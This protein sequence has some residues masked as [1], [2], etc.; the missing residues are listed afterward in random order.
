MQ[1]SIICAIEQDKNMFYLRFKD[2]KP[3]VLSNDLRLKLYKNGGKDVIKCDT[4][5]EYRKHLKESRLNKEVIYACNNE[6]NAYIFSNHKDLNHQMEDYNV[7]NFDIETSFDPDLGYGTINDPHQPVLTIS[8]QI[9]RRKAVIYTIKP[10][11]F[12]IDYEVK[13]FEKES[14]M[15]NAFINMIQNENVHIFTGW[16]I[17]YFDIPYF[18]ARCVRLNVDYLNLSPMKKVVKLID[19]ELDEVFYSIKLMH[20][21]DYCQLYKKFNYLNETYVKLN[22]IAKLELEESKVSYLDQY[23]NLRD[24]YNRNYKLFLEYNAR[25]VELVTE[26]DQKLNFIALTIKI[27]DLCINPNLESI[28]S[29]LS[30]SINL[31]I[32][33][34]ESLYGYYPQYIDQDQIQTLRKKNESY[35]SII[36]GYVLKPKPGVYKNIVILDFVSLYPSII[37]TFNI[38]TDTC[39]GYAHDINLVRPYFEQS[40]HKNYAKE[41]DSFFNDLFNKM[42]E[43]IIDSS[44]TNNLTGNGIV[45]KSTH[46][47]ALS[48]IMTDLFIQRQRVRSEMKVNGYKTSLDLEQLA[49]KILLNSQFGALGNKYFI[50]GSYETAESITSTGQ[51]IIKSVI[52]SLKKLG[53][54]VIYSDTDSI[55]ISLQDSLNLKDE[56]SIKEYVIK[57]LMVDIKKC[58]LDVCTKELHTNNNICLEMQL[59]DVFKEGIFWSTKKRYYLKKFDGNIKAKGISSVKTDLSVFYKEIFN[60]CIEKKLNGSNDD[61]IINY[62]MEIKNN[63]KSDMLSFAL[64]T[65]LKY[66]LNKYQ[67]NDLERLK[68][69]EKSHLKVFSLIECPPIESLSKDDLKEILD[70]YNEIIKK[71][72]KKYVQKAGEVLNVPYIQGT[73]AHFKG[74]YLFNHLI[75]EKKMMTKYEPIT[76]GITVMRLPLKNNS[77]HS[78]WL[79]VPIRYETKFE[80]DLID[81]DLVDYD[82]LFESNVMNKIKSEIL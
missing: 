21:L 34:W 56:N 35:G 39:L 54:K 46:P 8:Y 47:S 64:R 55:F 30:N 15:L 53:Y 16:N 2:F 42:S 59:E 38:G 33:Y 80:W 82:L 31:T 67:T 45:Y 4:L 10:I 20:I 3:F 11:N 13:C 40:S 78:S 28:F 27:Q 73:P 44:H 50:Y 77:Y 69:L 19:K 43:N 74:A 57:N 71:S 22:S 58:V 72:N 7:C 62:L 75:D 24:L 63:Y 14:E 79:S 41:R 5:F 66:N 9:N 68:T 23:D 32:K 61:E 76:G 51:Y 70:I 18:I 26:L 52:K 81:I 17:K 48:T 37:R 25:D 65:Q 49:Y 60:K 36:G 12:D 6:L 1:K 29:T